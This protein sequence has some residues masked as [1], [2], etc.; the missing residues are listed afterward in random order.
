MSVMVSPS[1]REPQGIAKPLSDVCAAPVPLLQTG[2]DRT[3]MELW[4][5]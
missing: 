4:T 5:L 3:S 1:L 2:D